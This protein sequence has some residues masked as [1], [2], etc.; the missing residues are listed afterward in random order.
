MSQTNFVSDVSQSIN[1]R[2]NNIFRQSFLKCSVIVTM[3][4][5]VSLPLLMV[6]G[7]FTS[8]SKISGNFNCFQVVDKTSLCLFESLIQVVEQ[9]F[10]LEKTISLFELQELRRPKT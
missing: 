8:T 5:P 2:V 9:T 3:N 10:V 6:A 1:C 7:L 4:L